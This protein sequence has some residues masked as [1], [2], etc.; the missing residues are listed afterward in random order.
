M[1]A[2]HRWSPDTNTRQSK[3]LSA[4]SLPK[5]PVHRTAVAG[6]GAPKLRAPE[7]K[8]IAETYKSCCCDLVCRIA[9]KADRAVQQDMAAKNWTNSPP[10]NTQAHATVY[11]AKPLV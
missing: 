5:N 7:E 9:R 10:S 8:S 1:Q 2:M 6:L 4:N 3:T 11:S